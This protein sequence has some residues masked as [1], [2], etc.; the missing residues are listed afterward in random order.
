MKKETIVITKDW[1]SQQWHKDKKEPLVHLMVGDV[2]ELREDGI[3]FTRKVSLG[4]ELSPLEPSFN[5]FKK[6]T[7]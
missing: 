3:Y 7:L 6:H 5:Q 2:V 1:V 4:N